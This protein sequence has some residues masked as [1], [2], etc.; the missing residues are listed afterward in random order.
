MI[1]RRLPY[2]PFGYQQTV[3]DFESPDAGHNGRLGGQ[4]TEDPVGVVVRFVFEGPC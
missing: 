2:Q 3:G 1:Q 4:S